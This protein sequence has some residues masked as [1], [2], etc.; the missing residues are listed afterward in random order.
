LN[1]ANLADANLQ[2]A[3]VSHADLSRAD[4]PRANFSGADLTGASLF[5]AD[6][7]GTNFTAA[8]M[9]ST[10]LTEALL[11]DADL[12]GASMLL[13]DLTNA[14]LSGAGMTG[15]D[16][17]LA[18]LT[19]ATCLDASGQTVPFTLASIGSM[20]SRPA[21]PSGTVAPA[22]PATVNAP[23]PTAPAPPEAS[24]SMPPSAG[25][26]AQPNAPSFPLPTAA[27]SPAPQPIG[28]TPDWSTVFPRHLTRDTMLGGRRLG[29]WSDSHGEGTYLRG[30]AVPGGSSFRHQGVPLAPGRSILRAVGPDVTTTS[31]F[32]EAP[33][34][35]PGSAGKIA[36]YTISVHDG[37]TGA[38]LS[39]YHSGASRTADE[40][41]FR[42]RQVANWAWHNANANR[43][44][45]SS[46]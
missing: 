43:D 25:P 44:I 40:V 46:T 14:D 21:A 15:A 13:A 35:E 16:L 10:N 23:A 3:N 7:C 9:R 20:P 6:L 42:T 36:P 41:A 5:R 32:T 19:G 37:R 8:S 22:T 24:A 11:R 17:I 27:P 2:G 39:E 31:R 34:D 18:N 12:S 4:L 45:A 1:G 26:G 28:D 33:Q 29:D 38:H 30:D